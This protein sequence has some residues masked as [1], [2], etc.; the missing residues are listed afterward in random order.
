MNHTKFTLFSLVVLASATSAFAAPCIPE[1]LS[2]YQ[3]TYGELNACSSG[4]L[5]YFSF[6]FAKLSSFGAVTPNDIY[7]TPDPANST[8]LFNGIQ[9][10]TFNHTVLAGQAEQ[11]LISYVIDPPPIVAGDDLTL[12][13]PTGPI[14]VSRWSCTEQP[15]SQ[16][17][18]PSSIT[19][20]GPTNYTA[21]SFQC[22]DGSTPYFLQVSPLTQLSASLTFA[23]PARY[24]FT[25]MAIDLLP[26]EHT[27]LEGIVSVT[28]TTIPEPGTFIPAALALAGMAF[29]RLR[30]R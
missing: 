5:N 8:L 14:Y 26:G 20:V 7:I 6:D 28:P 11:Y 23:V 9:Y 2:Y 17:P 22:I 16:A 21:G 4:V 24:V 12:D 10:S 1:T 27:G 15:F 19:G 3:T 25:R 29:H 18:S 13:P 30:R